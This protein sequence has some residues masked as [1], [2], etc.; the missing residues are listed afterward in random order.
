MPQLNPDPWFIIL[1]I[2]WLTFL[3]ILLPKILSHKTNNCPTPQSQD[4]LFLPPWNW[5]WL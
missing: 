4:K 5:P 2:S 3:L 1:L